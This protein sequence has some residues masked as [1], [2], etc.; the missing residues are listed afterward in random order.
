ML[1]DTWDSNEQPEKVLQPLQLYE[2]V[3]PFDSAPDP[4]LGASLIP[5]QRMAGP[6][7]NEREVQ[8][9]QHMIFLRRVEQ[10]RCSEQFPEH[11]S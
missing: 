3:S 5:V 4:R 9:R 7:A 2:P 8:L 1:A 6:R 11:A 10:V